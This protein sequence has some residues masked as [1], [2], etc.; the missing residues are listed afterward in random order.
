MRRPRDL[1][2]ADPRREAFRESTEEAVHRI[3]KEL[4]R[5]AQ[6]S[7]IALDDE[8]DPRLEL[9][10][11]ANNPALPMQLRVQ[12]HAEVAGFFYPKV[13]ALEL[14]LPEGTEMQVRI[15][16]FGKQKESPAIDVTPRKPN[17]PLN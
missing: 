10:K 5:W 7:N 3:R 9:A 16:K 8:Y 11:L 13:K 2:E 14:S 15:V 4:K 17:E 12:C 6:S 1:V